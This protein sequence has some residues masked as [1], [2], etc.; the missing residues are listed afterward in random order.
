MAKNQH[1]L[2][3][4][5]DE[6]MTKM[7]QMVFENAGHRVTTLHSGKEALDQ[8]HSIRPDCILS[9]LIMP[10]MNGLD[11]F[12]KI[13]GLPNIAQPKFIIVTVKPYEFDKRYSL[14]SGVD[15]YISK[16]INAAT[17]VDEVIA[18]IEGEM[19]VK[20]WGVRGSLPVPG[21]ASIRYGGNTSC[22]SLHIAKKNLL[23][24]DAGTGIKS[25]AAFLSQEKISPIQA[26][27]FITHP[28]YDHI[29]GLPFFAPLYNKG[30]DFEIF[31]TSSQ[32]IGVQQYLEGQMDSVY[33]P[34]TMN[35]FASKITFHNLA[36][37]TVLLDDIAVKTI[38]LNHPGG[39]I[40]Y[41]VQYRDKTFC[42]ITDNEILPENSP[43]YSLYEKN[44]LVQFIKGA[45]FVII[46]ATYTDY[47]FMDKR[48]WGH[49]CIA[50][51]VDVIDQAHVKTA[52]LFHHDPDQT[53]DDIDDKL[54]RATTLLEER[55]SESKCIAAHEGEAIV[56]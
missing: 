19:V 56:I 15:G 20:F 38:Y 46:D 27:I 22:V 35:E 33:F 17:I 43:G 1:F 55:K 25:L 37:E 42:Y 21:P 51:V 31:G 3:I 8:I 44:R 50:E 23:I 36:E 11:L 40:G 2:I 4:D 6:E 12:K 32:G 7:F 47:A 24:F 26:K 10:E 28:H 9:D 39:C 18:M 34:V 16:P 48:F 53:D 45:D 30:N 5:D 41:H 29:Q 14:Q 52:C 49:S 13:R 54:K